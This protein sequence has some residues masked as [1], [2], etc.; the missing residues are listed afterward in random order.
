M[1]ESKHLTRKE[2]LWHS[3]VFYDALG[4]INS[5]HFIGISV[6]VVDLCMLAVP[7]IVKMARLDDDAAKGEHVAAALV[8]RVDPD[9]FIA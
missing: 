9:E 3:D 1:R 4:N 5:L 6:R 8:A 2:D 7:R